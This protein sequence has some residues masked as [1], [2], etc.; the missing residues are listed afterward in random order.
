[1]KIIVFLAEKS[2]VDRSNR[3]RRDGSKQK[4]SSTKKSSNPRAKRL[5]NE[6][7]TSQEVPEN[8]M[9]FDNQSRDNDGMGEPVEENKGQIVPGQVP[10][11]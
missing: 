7:E 5:D 2:S 1:M 3:Q 11:S 10:R 4:K 6:D 8:A 9:K